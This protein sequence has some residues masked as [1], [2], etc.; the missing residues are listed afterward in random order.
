MKNFLLVVCGVLMTLC[1]APHCHAQGT[2]VPLPLFIDGNGSITPYQD[3]QLLEAGQNYEMTAIPDAGFVFSSWQPVNVYTLTT[4]IIDTLGGSPQTNISTST[5]DSP[6]PA[7]SEQ[8]TLDFTMSPINVV[9]SSETSTLTLTTGWQ[10]NFTAVPEPSSMALMMIGFST[11]VVLKG[12]RLYKGS[13]LAFL[14][15]ANFNPAVSQA[16]SKTVDRRWRGCP[17]RDD[18]AKA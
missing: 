5:D 8:T 1:L 6:L 14:R 10:A 7:T 12:R 15:P 2:L 9:Y 11:I 16:L 3:G 18:I 13:L 17:D 4:D